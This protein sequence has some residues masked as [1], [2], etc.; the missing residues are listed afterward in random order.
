MVKEKVMKVKSNKLTYMR[1][2]K[3]ILKIMDKKPKI[4]VQYINK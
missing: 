3:L 1:I 2:V 4:K